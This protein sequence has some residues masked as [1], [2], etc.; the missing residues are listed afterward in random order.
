[1]PRPNDVVRALQRAWSR[2][3]AFRKEDRNPGCG[4]GLEDLPGNLR[5]V[6]DLPHKRDDVLSSE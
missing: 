1:M 2:G 4:L 3:D 5:P 6:P